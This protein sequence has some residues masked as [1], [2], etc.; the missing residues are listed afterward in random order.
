MA[1]LKPIYRADT[2]GAAETALDGLEAKWDEQY[3]VVIQSWLTKW[4]LVSAYFKYP[5][6]IRKPIYTANSVN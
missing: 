3:G 2:K 1:D 6:A 5:K 4:H